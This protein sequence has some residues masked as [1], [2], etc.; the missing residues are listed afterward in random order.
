MVCRDFFSFTDPPLDH[1]NHAV[2]HVFLGIDQTS[3]ITVIRWYK[4]ANVFMFRTS[5]VN[6][7]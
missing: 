4:S 5:Q 3:P 2:E 6:V 1:A 7:K